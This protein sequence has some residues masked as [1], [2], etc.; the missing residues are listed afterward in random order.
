[1][2]DNITPV[3]II[4]KWCV[5]EQRM[6]QQQVQTPQGPMTIQQTVNVPRVF[7]GQKEI[8]RYIEEQYTCADQI[9]LQKI[10][11][12]EEDESNIEYFYDEEEDSC[13]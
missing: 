13:H 7:R 2:E 11:Y 4:N 8:Q 3:L 6:V 9:V 10:E 1:M 5:M 12:S